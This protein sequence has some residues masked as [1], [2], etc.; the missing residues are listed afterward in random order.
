MI[1]KIEKIL[2]ILL[3]V[4]GVAGIILLLLPQ[5]VGCTP[6]VV[7][8]GSMEPAV[9]VGSI[10]Y[11][12]RWIRQENIKEDDIIAYGLSGG[13][14]V[15]HR[16]IEHDKNNRTWIT[17]GDAN[18]TSDPGVV[19]YEQYLGKMVLV[20]PYVGYLTELLKKRWVWMAAVTVGIFVIVVQQKE[21]W[22]RGK[23]KTV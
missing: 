20:I 2:R 7:I 19:S 16:V 23:E 8:S 1:K 11:T 13:V 12:S 4:G 9:P 5:T 14:S 21:A 6:H 18:D 3:T 22:K 15:L 10:V 17:K